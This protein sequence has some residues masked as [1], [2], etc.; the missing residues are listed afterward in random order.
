M[1]LAI[2]G[3]MLS[4]IWVR[5]RTRL[6]AALL[7]LTGPVV[8]KSLPTSNI[9]VIAM[10]LGYFGVPRAS[11]P[12]GL[13][14]GILGVILLGGVMIGVATPVLHAP[15]PAISVAAVSE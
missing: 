11:R 13:A 10:I 8:E 12:R 1:F 3:G 4:A 14:H 5:Y 7:Y 9:F 6:Q 2:C 15:E